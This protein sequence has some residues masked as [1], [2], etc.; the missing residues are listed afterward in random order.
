MAEGAAPETNE[1]R[2]CGDETWAIGALG[3]HASIKMCIA[4]GAEYKYT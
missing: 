2:T 4:S 3:T 1:L